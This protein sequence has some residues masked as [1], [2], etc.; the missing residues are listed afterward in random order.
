MVRIDI[1]FLMMAII[2]GMALSPVAVSG[3]VRSL[4]LQSGD[5]L[6]VS[7]ALNIKSTVS[8]MQGVK[9]IKV[10][11][12]A[13]TIHVKY[14]DSKVS[15]EQIIKKIRDLGFKAEKIKV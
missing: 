7:C 3:A 14:D 5:L 15:E 10:S 2:V 4:D 6:C 13:K 8:R 11:A 1:L 12:S 9:D